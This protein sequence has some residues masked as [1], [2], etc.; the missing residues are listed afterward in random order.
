VVV[1]QKIL[2]CVA[3][4]KERF[5][6]THV[7]GVLRGENT[8]AIRNRGHDRLST[9]GLLK[10]H[11]KGDVRDWVYQ[12]LG[13]GVLLQEGEE[14]PLL[15]LN[16]ASW[17][18]MRGQRQVRLVQPVRKK[19]GEKAERAKVDTAS[20]EGVDKDLFDAL[21][22][23]RRRFA[24]QRQVQ[25]YIV[26]SD[27]TLRDLARVRPSTPEA[28]RLVYGV[29]E[30]KL[31][32]F[33]E[34]FLTLVREHCQQHGLSMDESAPAPSSRRATSEGTE[35]RPGSVPHRAFEL[36]RQGASIDAVVEQTGRVRGTVLN[37]LCDFLRRERPVDLTPWV[38]EERYKRIAEAARRVGTDRLKPIFVALGEQVSYD[39]IRLVVTH[40]TL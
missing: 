40:L 33:G 26:F 2:S 3:R 12:L 8:E 19:K 9:Y 24:E 5:G 17:E 36:F 10:E 39:E 34:A 4:V 38:S 21:R 27:A 11:P 13:Q 1:A 35:V 29:G 37:Y 31:R 16:A 14:Y 20:W 25:P 30:T 22:H 15:K 28:M 7:V 6:I 18:V 23:L 32:D